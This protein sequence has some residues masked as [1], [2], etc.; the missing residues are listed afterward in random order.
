MILW[1]DQVTL[2]VTSVLELS[3]AFTNADLVVMEVLRI[4][5]DLERTVSA[6]DMWRT[7]LL[8]RWCSHSKGAPCMVSALTRQLENSSTP[9][10]I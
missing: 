4:S 3:L 1:M 6:L 2:T 5:C 7:V 10:P 9:D 8:W